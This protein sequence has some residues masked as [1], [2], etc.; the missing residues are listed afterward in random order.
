MSDLSILP[1]HKQF[2]RELFPNTYQWFDLFFLKLVYP[3]K[4]FH[5]FWRP[6][7]FRVITSYYLRQIAINYTGFCTSFVLLYSRYTPVV[8]R[9]LYSIILLLS[10]T[11]SSKSESTRSLAQWIHP[12]FPQQ[13]STVFALEYRS[14]FANAIW[15]QRI[16]INTKDITCC[17]DG[18]AKKEGN[19]EKMIAWLNVKRSTR[20]ATNGLMIGETAPTA[21]IMPWVA[22]WTRDGKILVYL[23]NVVATSQLR[24]NTE[25]HKR[26]CMLKLI[27]TIP[28]RHQQCEPIIEQANEH[29][30]IHQSLILF[31]DKYRTLINDKT[32]KKAPESNIALIVCTD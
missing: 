15:K 10:Y 27:D 11:L 16:W 7:G 14:E 18:E 22:P 25:E 12:V 8:T 3:F 19:W 29:S 2:M 23:A 32:G 1:L 31:S 9:I 17:K 28:K 24:S 5:L 20:T 21:I 6:F 30:S 4:F 13:C 26:R